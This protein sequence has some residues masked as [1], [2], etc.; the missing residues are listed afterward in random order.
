[1]LEKVKQVLKYIVLPLTAL[2]GFIYYLLQDRKKLQ[3]ELSAQKANSELGNAL[4]RLDEA[5]KGAEESEKSYEEIRNAI[6]NDLND[7]DEPP[8]AS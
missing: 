2:F 3:N 4:S 5:K 7:D 1:M 6:V 8:R